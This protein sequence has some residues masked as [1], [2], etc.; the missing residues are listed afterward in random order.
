MSTKKQFVQGDVM[1]IPRRIKGTEV[2]SRR[3][4]QGDGLI[5]ARGEETGH[6]HVLPS[7]DIRVIETNAGQQFV[8]IIRQTAMRHLSEK[9]GQPTNEHG[10][11]ALSPG[12]YEVRMQRQY[13][14]SFVD[15]L[16]EQPRSVP[17]YNFE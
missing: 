12:T 6:I 5:V 16:V 11:R 2:K 1:F 9:T 17:R 14:D 15:N 3:S 4:V 8:E 7:E 13:D 10:D